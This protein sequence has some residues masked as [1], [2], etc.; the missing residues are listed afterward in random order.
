MSLWREAGRDSEAGEG[1]FGQ[2][3]ASPLELFFLSPSPSPSSFPCVCLCCCVFV[4]GLGGVFEG[5]EGKEKEALFVRLF[6][7]SLAGEKPFSAFPFGLFSGKTTDVSHATQEHLKLCISPLGCW[8]GWHWQHMSGW[9][10][11]I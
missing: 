6:G 3:T 10:G 1:Q 8:Q 9:V 5:E 11:S 7:F 4:V 2:W